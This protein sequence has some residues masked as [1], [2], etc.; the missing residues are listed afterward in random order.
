MFSDL[1]Q[2]LRYAARMLALTLGIVANTAIFS[3]VNRVLLQPLPFNNPGDLV[4]YGKNA[5]F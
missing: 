4:I 5:T 2:D 3:F 1:G